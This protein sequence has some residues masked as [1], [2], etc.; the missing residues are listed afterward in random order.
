VAPYD[1]PPPHLDPSIEAVPAI[2]AA[3]VV[4][5]RDAADGGI[6]VLLLRRSSKLSFAGGM[7]VFPG[8]RVDDADRAAL[9][10]IAATLAGAVDDDERVARIAAAREAAEE[11]GVAVEPQALEW[12]AHW[13][14][15]AMSNKR[16]ATWFFVTAAHEAL[17]DIAVDGGEIHDHGWYSPAGALERCNRREID[18][19]PPTWITLEY[20]RLF[21]RVDALVD[22]ARRRPAEFFATRIGTSGDAIVALYDGDAGY[23]A[24][25][26]AAPGARHRLWM[27]PDGWRYERDGWP[28]LLFT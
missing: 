7:W 18:L 3:T 24:S 20:L 22:H 10:P 2:P 25:D 27:A 6:E 19:S 26:P 15:P 16:F 12:F 14:P 17:G 9:E 13:T 5:A 23:E 4:I 21:D 8:G 28:D 11:A 1:P